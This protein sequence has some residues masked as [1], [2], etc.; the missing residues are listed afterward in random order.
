[1]LDPRINAYRPDLADAA[2]EGKVEAER[3]V[4]GSLRRIGAPVAPVRTAPSSDASLAT[5]ALL[6]EEVRVFEANPEGWAWAQLVADRYVGW[7]PSEALAESEPAP[8]HRV[9]V[10]RTFVFSGPDI[11]QPPLATL[12]FGAAVT[13]RREAEDRN[14]RYGIVEPAGAIVMQHLEP[15]D[16]PSRDP[17]AAAE[18]FLGTPYLWGGRTALGIDCSGLVQIACRAAG[19]A[20]PRDSDMQLSLGAPIE[21]GIG[22]LRRGD[23][24]FWKGH[25]G[26]MRDAGTLLHANAWHMMAVVEPLGD[27]IARFEARGHPLLALRRI[28]AE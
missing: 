27:A 28:F 9:R 5:E 1:M 16:A 3:F 10:A 23:L 6:G 20:A 11:K 14:A 22:D 2:L 26:I 7:L 25:V 18:L 8:T 12:S 21:G 24:V 13:V 4:R 17:V 15:V 19:I